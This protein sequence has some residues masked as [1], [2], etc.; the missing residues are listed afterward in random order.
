MIKKQTQTFN[1]GIVKIFD[2]KNGAAAGDKPTEVLEIKQTL[3]YKER[4]VG[5][6]RYLD[7][8]QA[9]IKVDYVL[10]CPRIDGVTSQDVAI[11]L[12]GKQYRI[13]QVQYPEDVYPPVMDLTLEGVTAQYAIN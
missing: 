12:D 13:V 4:T 6:K 10:R 9:H 5:Y 11:P 3:R 7:A 8:L 1:D 2:V